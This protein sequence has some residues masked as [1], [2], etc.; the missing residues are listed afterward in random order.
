MKK[1]GQIRRILVCRT[2]NIG[3][4]VLTIPMIT[5]LKR[6]WPDCQITVLA[7]DYI[8]AVVEACAEIDHFMSWD[9]LQQQSTKEQIAALKTQQF[10]VAINAHANNHALTKLI[11]QAKIPI[12]IGRGRRLS[13]RLYLNCRLETAR[14][15]KDQHEAE[16]NMGLI[17]PLGISCSMPAD[18]LYELM[19]LNVPAPT[20]NVLQFLSK[21]KFNLVL[22]PFS[23]K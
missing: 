15:L 17:E 1:H 13:K 7:R 12:R 20:E 11:Y 23:N 2:D 6:T 21:D 3:D 16:L 5:L 8:Q 14:L 4:M 22:H 18:D 19:S 10:D 9:T